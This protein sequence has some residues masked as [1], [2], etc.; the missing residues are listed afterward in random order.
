MFHIL[1][2]SIFNLYK[3]IKNKNK[4]FKSNDIFKDLK[5]FRK[6]EPL[7]I[8]LDRSKSDLNKLNIDKVTKEFYD[9]L[10]FTMDTF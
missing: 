7:F 4:I 8:K 9:F 6:F 10:I 3:F 2:F 1:K 5:E